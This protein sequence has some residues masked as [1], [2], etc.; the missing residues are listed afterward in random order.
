MCVCVFKRLASQNKIKICHHVEAFA[1]DFAADFA[2]FNN[3]SLEKLFSELKLE[4]FK[5]TSTAIKFV[6][7]EIATADIT[8]YRF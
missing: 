7:S 4:S 2:N 5:K 6:L 3:K 8:N 1:A